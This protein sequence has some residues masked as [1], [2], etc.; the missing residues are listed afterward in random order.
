MIYQMKKQI[1]VNKFN[2]EGVNDIDAD[3]QK[4]VIKKAK[5]CLFNEEKEL[6]R[7]YSYTGPED[8]TVI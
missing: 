4:C 1:M 3:S 6:L 2:S 5:E 8:Y 7:K